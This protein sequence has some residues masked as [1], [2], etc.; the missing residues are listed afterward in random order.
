MFGSDSTVA[1]LKSAIRRDLASR[2]INVS[3]IIDVELTRGGNG[4]AVHVGVKSYN[5][6]LLSAVENL[7][8]NHELLISFRDVIAIPYLGKSFVFV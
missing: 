2:G 3:G 6:E 8:S 4:R 5:N 1:E 7:I